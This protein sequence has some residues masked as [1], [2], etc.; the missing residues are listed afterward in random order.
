MAETVNL[1]THK[2]SKRKLKV[3]INKSLPALQHTLPKKWLEEYRMKKFFYQKFS[4]KLDTTL[5]SL[6][7]G[8]LDI[9]PNFTH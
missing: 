1:F 5:N 7:N 4:K 9:A 2:L 6:E 3:L 8:I